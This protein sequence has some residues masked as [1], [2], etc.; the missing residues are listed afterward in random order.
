MDSILEIIFTFIETIVSNIN[1][2]W[3]FIKV[4]LVTIPVMLKD[5][6]TNLPS[7]FQYSLG[8][9]LTFVM[10]FILA[11]FVSLVRAVKN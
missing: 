8:L 2:L 11:R 3:T 9:F 5:I 6:F 10:V 1:D 7:F 4:F